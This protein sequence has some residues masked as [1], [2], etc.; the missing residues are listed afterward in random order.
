[1]KMCSLINERSN[2]V[3]IRWSPPITRWR[4]TRWPTYTQRQQQDAR[5]C[6][7]TDAS[8]TRPP[9]P[10]SESRHRGQAP[11]HGRMDLKPRRHPPAPSPGRGLRCRHL[12]GRIFTK[13]FTR[14]IRTGAGGVTPASASPGSASSPGAPRER[15]RHESYGG[16]ARLCEWKTPR[17]P[18]VQLLF[19]DVRAAPAVLSFLRDTRVGRMVPLA[20]REEWR[21]EDTVRGVAREEGKACRAY[22]RMP[23]FFLRISLVSCGFPVRLSLVLF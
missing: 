21:G 22:R 5:H 15:A 14:S 4:G 7:T 3:T 8:W 10:H 17:A 11:G 12:I 2:Q 19:D 13:R 20:L 9:S 1:M 6:A 16:G 23:L 18:A